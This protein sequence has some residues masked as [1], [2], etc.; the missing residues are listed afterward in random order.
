MFFSN[1][2]DYRFFC[3]S[4]P[5]LTYAAHVVSQIC[6]LT[7]HSEE[8]CGFGPDPSRLFPFRAGEHTQYAAKGSCWRLLLWWCGGPSARRLC[9]GL[10][11]E[12]LCGTLVGQEMREA[13]HANSD[14]QSRR[15]SALPPSRPR[16]A[17]AKSYEPESGRCSL[18]L[19]S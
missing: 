18:I 14:R 6:C 16:R 17:R 7:G 4:T 19:L 13:T 11:F 12:T 10:R 2:E 9:E 1:F 8:G 5:I 3:P 15:R